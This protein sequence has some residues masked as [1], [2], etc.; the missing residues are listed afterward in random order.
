MDT[1]GEAPIENMEAPWLRR[2]L[3]LVRIFALSVMAFLA[4]PIVGLSH[5]NLLWYLPLAGFG[6]GYVRAIW[7]NTPQLH[8]NRAPWTIVA[9]LLCGSILVPVLQFDWFSGLTFFASV[10][11]LVNFPLRWWRVIVP[12]LIVTALV[13]SAVV[14]RAD[15]DSILFLAVQVLVGAGM[16]VVIYTQM[17]TSAELHKARVELAQLAVTKERL[18]IARDLHDSLGQQLSAIT[19]KADVAARIVDSDPQQAIIE[20][21]EVGSLARN[22]LAAARAVVSGYRQ[23]SL[24][25]EAKAAETLLRT[26]GLE[27]TARGLERELPRPV[28]ECAGWV[29][30]EAVTNVVRHARACR[31]EIEVAPTDGAVAVEVRDDGVGA[32]LADPPAYG[33]GLTGLAER[34]ALTDAELEVGSDDGWFTVRAVLP[35]RGEPTD[36]RSRSTPVSYDLPGPR[37]GPDRSPHPSRGR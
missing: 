9:T 5:E 32:K 21:T 23:V 16:Q 15:A 30:R 25:A 10:M 6:I 36:G 8:G 12:G 2:R 34:L 22:G 11:L 35:L 33:T 4:Y 20:M 37:A 31:C 24:A 28:D 26:S 27:V 3:L 18:R 19:L 13:V 14:L 17:E 7:R 1:E 29:V